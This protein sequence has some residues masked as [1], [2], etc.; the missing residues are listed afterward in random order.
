MA[1]AGVGPRK[2]SG[3]V[4]RARHI[5]GARGLDELLDSS[6]VAGVKVVVVVG[7]W[8]IWV[9]LVCHVKGALIVLGRKGGRG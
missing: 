8:G 9:G 6:K 1:A 7:A 5:L 3:C 2:R 4:F